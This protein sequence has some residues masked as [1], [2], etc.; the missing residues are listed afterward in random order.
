MNIK[1]VVKLIQGEKTGAIYHATILTADD[2][3]T[4]IE[5]LRNEMSAG[6]QVDFVL[7]DFI[8]VETDH[9]H[10][11]P[12]CYISIQLPFVLYRTQCMD[13]RLSE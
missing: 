7:T 13:R 9:C 2:G 4:A 8:M 11:L 12:W 6:R 1:V 5:Q 10:M 3:T